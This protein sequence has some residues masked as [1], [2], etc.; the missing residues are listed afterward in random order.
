MDGD[1]VGVAFAEGD[2]LPEWS[3][4]E[5]TRTHFVRYAGASGDF[6]PIH[7]DEVAARRLGYESVF[8]PGM[9]TAGLLAGY[10]TR[11]VGVDNLRRYGVRFTGQ[12]W[13]GDVLTCRGSVE[14]AGD[15]GFDLRLEVVNQHGATVVSGA[16]TAVVRPT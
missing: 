15:D 4:A 5:L 3:T 9:L 14:R 12:V 16:A 6:N 13:P 1:G 8:G 11:L 10:V 7:H 2:D